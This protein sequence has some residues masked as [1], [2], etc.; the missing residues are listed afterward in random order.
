MIERLKS[1]FRQFFNFLRGLFGK[2]PKLQLTE[3]FKE[4]LHILNDTGKSVF[5][6]GKA[7]T[8]KS[9]LLQMFI[10]GTS[11]KIVVLAPT[12]VAALNVGG[13]TIHSFFK[14]PAG[15]R[16]EWIRP[17]Y[18]RYDEFRKVELIVIDE[19]SMVRSDLMDC[20]DVALR[21]NRNVD[22][23]FGGVQMV[24]VGDLYQLPPVLPKD[25]CCYIFSRYGGKHFFYAPV[26]GNYLFERRE[27]SHVFR[28]AP[29][30]VEFINLLNN[31]RIGKPSFEDM[32][33]LHKRHVT[34]AG[35]NKKSIVLAT[36]RRN[37]EKINKERLEML[38]GEM[39]TYEC[40]ATGT[41]KDLVEKGSDDKKDKNLPAPERLNLKV[42]ASI[43]M[44]KNDEAHRWVNGSLGVVKEL[45]EDKVRVKIEKNECFV[46]RQ[47][48]E[49]KEK[50]ADGRD[51]DNVLG[52]FEQF[53][54][55]LAYAITIHK[56][57]GKTF[58]SI[59]IN[60]GSGAFEAGQVYVAL[61]R[62]RSFCGITLE[63]RID[64]S[65][66]YSDDHV[67]AFLNNGI[68]ERVTL[69]DVMDKNEII[70]YAIQNN[71]DIIITYPSHGSGNI[72]ERKLSSVKYENQDKTIVRGYC[73]LRN[74]PRNFCIDKIQSIKIV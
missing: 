20:V 51:K 68:I 43:I 40:E 7:G 28:Q 18:E 38:P 35:S 30:E 14:F 47:R 21:K 41:Y 17:S 4:I 33:L 50:G 62:C 45:L 26:F 56:S 64:S 27:L 63:R 23:P 46:E 9:T 31:I 25:E 72:E 24:F 32:V 8:G 65:E 22:A 13:R 29:K 69:S 37:A 2:K 61:S 1:L 53:P 71:R 12:G 39:F 70:E 58:D 57:Q 15:V 49:D 10:K 3:E 6:T 34:N 5:I 42:G 44:V 59:C 36:C 19:V 48:W 67:E 11:K 60:T 74:E 54:M 73:N 55:Q 52:T 16:P 66:I